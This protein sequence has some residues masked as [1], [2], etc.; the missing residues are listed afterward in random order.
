M[1]SNLFAAS[2]NKV[3][4]PNGLIGLPQYENNVDLVGF[5]TVATPNFSNW[6]QNHVFSVA[7]IVNGF[8]K[9]NEVLK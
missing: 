1:N 6:A 3:T 4:V 8:K 2:H 5:N 7:Y 9:N